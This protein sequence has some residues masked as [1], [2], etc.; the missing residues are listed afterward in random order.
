[1]EAWLPRVQP[2][3]A[4]AVVKLTGSGEADASFG[5]GGL[6]MV[7]GLA[8]NQNLGFIDHSEGLAVQGDGKILVAKRT[9]DGHFGLVRLNSN[10]TFDST[11]G[12][13]GIATANFG[14]QDDADSV[15][16]E[17]TG[18]I[19]VV[20]TSLL[21]NTPMTA[22]A[23]FDSTGHPIVGFGSD[24]MVTFAAATLHHPGTAYR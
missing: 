21:N 17:N 13:G 24:G 9:T 7:N 16:I 15:L 11:F 1:M 12:N 23:A 8:A 4:V 2:D 10:G 20:G 6:V 18:Q 5:N 19:I 3:P 22:V 14:G